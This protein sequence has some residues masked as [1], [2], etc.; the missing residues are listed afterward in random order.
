MTRIGRCD[1]VPSSEETLEKILE[2]IRP[3]LKQVLRNYD[4][5][6]QDAEDVLQETFLEALRKWDTIRHKDS[7]LVGA[8]RFKCSHYWKKQ[9]SERVQGVDLPVLEELSEPQAP[10]QE[11][12]EILL[13]LRRL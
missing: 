11:Q 10:A 4:I 2:R 6:P 12:G 3:R 9:R 5:P 8:L 1:T 7:W 13:D